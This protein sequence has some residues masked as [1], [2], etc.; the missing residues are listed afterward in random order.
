MLQFGGSVKRSFWN[1]FGER[2]KRRSETYH[3]MDRSGVQAALDEF[4]LLWGEN[5]RL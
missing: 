1:I 3:S 4:Y 2:I 5:G